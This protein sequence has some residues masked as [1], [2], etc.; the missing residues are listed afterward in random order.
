MV[1]LSE[2]GGSL[3]RESAIPVWGKSLR[4]EQNVA[5]PVGEMFEGEGE[6]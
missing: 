4:A 6:D 1:V 5:A 2:A 3:R